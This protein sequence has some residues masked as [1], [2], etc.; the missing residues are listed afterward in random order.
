MKRGFA[1]PCVHSALP[2]TRRLQLQLL[3]VDQMSS[4][5]RRAGRPVVRLSSPA[6]T[7]SA[8][9]AR[10]RRTFFANPKIKSTLLASHHV[11]SASRAKP[12]VSPQN[13]ACHRPALADLRHDASHLLHGTRRAID[14]CGPQLCGQQVTAAED[15]QRQITVAIVVTV[16]EPSFL[17][18]MQ[19][20]VGGVEIEDNLPG[21]GPVR[22][23]QERD[24]QPLNGCPVVGNLVITRRR[25]PA[26]S[27]RLSV[28]LPAT[29]AQSSRCAASL[30]ASTAITGSWRRSS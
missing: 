25:L 22:V 18:P 3:R 1:S 5:K 11:M 23:Q 26:H 24:E 9:I 2:I 13:D 7:S 6:S 28:D 8:P 16:E 20:I 19:R 27:R 17:M 21:R 30:P 14:V 15:V 12:G 4:L 29:G 10:L